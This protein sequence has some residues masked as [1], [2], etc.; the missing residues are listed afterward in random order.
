M[1][2]LS[3]QRYFFISWRNF[4]RG[5]LWGMQNWILRMRRSGKRGKTKERGKGKKEKRD[6]LYSL[7]KLL[8]PWI[9]LCLKSIPPLSWHRI[10]SVLLSGLWQ[11]KLEWDYLKLK[12][13]DQ[14]RWY[15]AKGW[16]VQYNLRIKP[17]WEQWKS[18]P[19]VMRQ[20]ED[21][22]QW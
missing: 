5:Q 19:E 18:W 6:W 4:A 15:V 10:Y 14:Y 11:F 7:K 1:W 2:I 16:D 9:K 20:A 12:P 21:I 22:I 3:F 8:E 17:S 13:P